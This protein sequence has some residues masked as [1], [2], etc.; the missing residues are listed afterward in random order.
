MLK[1]THP[2]ARRFTQRAFE[3]Q[4]Q[5]LATRNLRAREEYFASARWWFKLAE[6]FDFSIRLDRLLDDPLLADQIPRHP[7]C[8]VCILPMNLVEIQCSSGTLE[9]R[10]ECKGCG[11]ER[12]IVRA[13]Q[14]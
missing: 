13:D 10:F 6:S 12:M 3:A 2:L 14:L 7:A 4:V 11:E 1:A 5:A 8:P 9:C